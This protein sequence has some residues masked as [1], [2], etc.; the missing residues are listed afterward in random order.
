MPNYSLLEH[1][2][3]EVF[4]LLRPQA[5]NIR[6]GAALSSAHVALLQALPCRVEAD[7]AEQIRPPAT[8]QPDTHSNSAIAC[9]AAKLP[10]P[11]RT[12][13]SFPTLWAFEVHTFHR[14][15]CV[16]IGAT[17]TFS[18]NCSQSSKATLLQCHCACEMMHTLDGTGSTFQ[19][20]AVDHANL[21]LMEHTC[22]Q[23]CQQSCAHLRLCSPASYNVSARTGCAAC[24]PS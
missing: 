4:F 13:G 15:A 16:K 7:F 11:S 12:A 22:C 1:Y 2:G 23:P 14:S 10:V 3:R 21:E 8:P 6:L 5:A 17:S 18:R 9:C 19:G 24:P 20:A